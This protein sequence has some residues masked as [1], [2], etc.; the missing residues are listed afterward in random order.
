MLPCLLAIAGG[1]GAALRLAGGALLALLDT[2][3]A[4]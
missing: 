1:T 4:R 3:R 2:R